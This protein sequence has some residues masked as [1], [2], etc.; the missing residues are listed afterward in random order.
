M[1]FLVVSELS[2]YSATV[3]QDTIFVDVSRQ[4]RME[5]EFDITFIKLQCNDVQVDIIDNMSQE[6]FVIS[7]DVQKVDVDGE[8]E[9]VSPESKTFFNAM[10][11]M[12]R[13]ETTGCRVKGKAVVTRVE[14]SMH[15]AA[16]HGVQQEHGEHKHHT[17]HIKYTDL[18]FDFSHRVNHL[19]FGP[20]WPG[21]Q[22][23]LDGNLV[24]RMPM[25]QV[26]YLLKVVPTIFEP[27]HG[28]V[29]N[30]HQFSVTENIKEAQV[31]AMSFPLP[32]V[33]FKWDICPFVV[34]YQEV[35]RG[36][37]H[38]LTRICA[39]A[40]GTFVVL[41]LVYKGIQAAYSKLKEK[42]A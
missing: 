37:A 4:E 23:P 8:R 28:Q 9:I 16:G 15:I 34:K 40:G 22:D 27:L 14:G 12:R 18:N 30:T 17:H 21:R 35:S 38:F 19:S 41:G 25:T 32:G 20:Y 33:F 7:K 10:A 1:L 24:R 31:G 11:F 42:N 5:L 26:N 29:I 2:D 13:G 3:T 36:F 39:I 6:D